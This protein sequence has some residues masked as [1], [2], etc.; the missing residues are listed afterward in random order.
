MRCS[1]DRLCAA[2]LL[3]IIPPPVF[4]GTAPGPG[5]DSGDSPAVL[6]VRG[7]DRSGGFLE[8]GN[9]TAR[10]EQLADIT[11]HS[12]SGGNHG[13]FEL[14]ELLRANGFVVSQI[15]EPLETGAPATGPTTGA[16][17]AFAAMD[18]SVYDAIV[19][20]SNNADY[21]T[22]FGQQQV[23]AIEA[24]VRSGGGVLFI[25][26]A[27]F[28]GSWADAPTSD[29]AFLDRFGW[30]MQQDR[31]TYAL[32]RSD[33]DFVTPDHPVVA[34]PDGTTIIDVIDG[35]GVSPIVV[36]EADTAPGVS[37]TIVVRARPGQQT[38]N[39]D[40]FPGQGTSRPVGPQ[41]ATL[42]V[43]DVD[44]GR[45]AGHID[46][47]TFFNLNGAGTNINRFDNAA[48]AVNL[49]TWLVGPP[50]NPCGPA[51][52]ADL[53]LPCGV[54][55]LADVGAFIAAFLGMDDAVDFDGSGTC[56]L[57]DIGACVASF[58]AGCP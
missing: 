41:D 13:W 54:L 11:N 23:D 14:A 17:L 57:A 49:F 50:S 22:P 30:T 40:R 38:R 26:D 35:E 29:Q 51:C 19:L 45:I 28:G 12:T 27:N 24:Y 43:A 20:G 3:T 9:D 42:A 4:A 2:L 39:N 18:L 44:S 7:A 55:A 47:N 56:D 33:G 15:A 1:I 46:R 36:P 32:R 31:G 34:G 52:P 5:L 37:S 8:A 6:F 16:P 21:A 25:S 53:A 58:T 48:Y 10:T